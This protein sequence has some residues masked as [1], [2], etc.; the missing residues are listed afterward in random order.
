MVLSRWTK[1]ALRLATI[2]TLVFVYVPIGLIVLYSFNSARWRRG[3][4][5]A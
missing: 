2:A 3:R 4:S 5:R 1:L